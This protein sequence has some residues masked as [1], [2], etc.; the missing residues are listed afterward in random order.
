MCSKENSHRAMMSWS[1][2][3][4]VHT[5][6]SL[7]MTRVPQHGIPA[8]DSSCPVTF[9]FRILQRFQPSA[10]ITSVLLH[11]FEFGKSISTEIAWSSI[12]SD[13]KMSG[14]D[15]MF[16]W[17]RV[18]AVPGWFHCTYPFESVGKHNEHIN[19]LPSISSVFRTRI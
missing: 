13:W 2:S 8:G 11:Q 19:T 5:T 15:I 14:T 12:G 10:F 1:R 4:I 17:F 18:L 9:W 6:H 3:F 7:T 16:K